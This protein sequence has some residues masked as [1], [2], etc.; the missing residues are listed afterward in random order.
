VK[1]LENSLNRTVT[2]Q[3]NQRGQAERPAKTHQDYWKPRLRHRSY[4]DQDGKLVKIPKWQVRMFHQ[5]RETWFNLDTA[6]QTSSCPSCALR[7]AR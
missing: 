7:T 6:N 2:G 3:T 1:T 5:N 4:R